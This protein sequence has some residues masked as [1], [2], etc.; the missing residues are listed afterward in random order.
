MLLKEA[1]ERHTR[2]SD[3]PSTAARGTVLLLAHSVAA[4]RLL[5]VTRNLQTV[6]LG[7][8]FRVVSEISL[9]ALLTS[10]RSGP[11]EFPHPRPSPGSLTIRMPQYLICRD[12]QNI[13]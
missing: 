2:Y 9:G 11:P 1:E 12:G 10:M 3:N 5:A 7:C 6:L 8:R 4:L 13:L